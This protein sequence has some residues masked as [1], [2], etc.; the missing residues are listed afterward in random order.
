MNSNSNIEYLKLLGL[1]FGFAYLIYMYRPLSTMLMLSVLAY[2]LF[3]TIQNENRNNEAL[4]GA[5]YIAGAE[6]FFRMTGGMVFYETGKYMVIV[7]LIIGMVFKG[8]SSKTVPFWTYLLIL[9]PGIIVASITM[10]LEADFRKSIAF[11]L[12]GPVC[13]GVSALYCY[14]KKI[15]KEDFQKV[16]LMLL[17]PLISIMFYLYLYTPTLQEGLINMSGNYAA[18]GGYGPNQIS[19]VLGM[20]AFLIVTRLFAIKNK[21]INMIDI[22]LLGLMGY[23]AV[24]TF[25]RGGV[26]TALVCIAVFIILHYYKQERREQKNTN[27]KIILLISSILLIWVYSSIK[28]F[29][30][31]ENRYENRDSAGQLKDDITTGRIELVTTELDAFYNFP[32]TGIGVGKGYE[33]REETLGIDIAS[34]NE[35]SRLLSEHG[36]LGLIA[37]LILIFVPI[38]FWTKFKNNYYFLAF[39]AFWFLTINHSAMRIAMPA[40]VYG[41]ALLYIVDEKKPPVHRKRLSY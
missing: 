1:H 35:I 8:T 5:A 37:L 21:F 3:I 2:F 9:V 25:S 6:V 27:Y 29:G 34:H 30:L 31:I 11:N 19:T 39:M 22:I 13:L 23:R 20:G 12:S 18:T 4:M 16:I 24:I 10:S 14:Y 15:K 40:F 36:L 28:T 26:F 41:L 32:L 7:F 33:Y 17:M 38:L